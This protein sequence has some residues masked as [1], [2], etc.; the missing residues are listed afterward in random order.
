MPL[1]TP[2]SD[3]LVLVDTADRAVFKF[4][5][6][7][8]GT[9]A[10]ESD[11]L[12]VNTATLSYRTVTLTTANTALPLN[13]YYFVPGEQ[14]VGATSNAYGRVVSWKAPTSTVGG[15][16]QLRVVVESGTFQAENITGTRLNRTI[17]VAS[18]VVPTY[19][20]EITGL[21]WA[22][23]SPAAKVGLQWQDGAG[24]KHLITLAGTG[25][26]G[27]NLFPGAVLPNHAAAPT[28][29]L[30]ISTYNMAANDGYSLIV[31]VRKTKGFAQYQT[32]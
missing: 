3:N 8:G 7:A 9:P 10:Q 18:V 14:V 31:E 13:S 15:E 22:I 26:F 17:A 28:G 19:I 11:V 4:L 24:Y 30:H 21:L 23:S 16:G 20:V 6:H 2:S 27:K 29:N 1:T 12:K 32:Y 25:S 5:Y